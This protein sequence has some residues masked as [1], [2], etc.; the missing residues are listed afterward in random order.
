MVLIL[1]LVLRFHP[2]KDQVELKKKIL[3]I[4]NNIEFLKRNLEEA[5]KTYNKNADLKRLPSPNFEVGKKVWLLKRSTYK[6][7]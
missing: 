3:D 6:K 5:K 1:N 4:N 7:C 2:Q